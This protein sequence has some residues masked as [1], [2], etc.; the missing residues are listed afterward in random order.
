[1]RD[2]GMFLC[3]NGAR[4]NISNVVSILGVLAVKTNEPL[5][6]HDAEE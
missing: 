3:Q 5:E 2:K 4:N 6:G 1:M